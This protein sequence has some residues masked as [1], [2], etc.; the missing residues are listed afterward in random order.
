MHRPVSMLLCAVAAFAAFAAPAPVSKPRPSKVWVDGWEK[1]VDQVGDCGFT[2]VGDKLTIAVPPQQERSIIGVVRGAT[3]VTAPHMLRDVR[4]DFV[5]QVRMTGDFTGASGRHRAAGLLLKAGQHTVLL[6]RQ[7]GMPR[8]GGKSCHGVL[9]QLWEPL[10][11]ASWGGAAAR[12]ISVGPQNRATH[13]RLERRG[14]RLVTKWSLDGAE[15]AVLT[16]RVIPKLPERAKLGVFA[17]GTD[18]TL[19]EPVFDQFSLTPLK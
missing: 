12:E 10:G 8:G 14:D 9:S 5:V 13:L 3:S 19:F 6:M 17:Y 2:R 7:W 15:W 16:D 4:G 11:P 18:T 1:P